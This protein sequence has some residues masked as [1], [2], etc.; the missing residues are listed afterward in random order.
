MTTTKQQAI[1]RAMLNSKEF[2]E[3]TEKLNKRI[4]N[5]KNIANENAKT[6][7]KLS[8]DLINCRKEMIKEFEKIINNLINKNGNYGISG[9]MFKQSLQELGEK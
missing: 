6:C 9:E 5:F 7:A 3:E 8:D 4:L 1:K 2:K